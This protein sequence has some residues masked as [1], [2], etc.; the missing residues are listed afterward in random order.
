MSKIIEINP[1][2]ELIYKEFDE[3]SNDDIDLIVENAKK[4]KNWSKK[5]I[6]ERVFI[7]SKI[8]PILEEK[9]EKLAHTMASEMGKSL[10]SG[11]HEVSIIIKRIED[12]CEMIPSFIENEIIF[13]SET[14]KNIVHF[15]P[16]GVVAV[17]SPWNAPV[18]VPLA[19]IIPALLTGNNVV[20]KPS[21]YST[22]I[23]IVISEVFNELKKYG[24]PE[25]SFQLVIGGKDK[26]K[27]LVENDID[28]TVL[29]GSLRAGQQIAKSSSEKLKN[30]IL[31]LG[32]K[33]PAIVLEDADLDNSVIQIVKAATMYTGQVCFGVE[34]VYCHGKIYDEFIEKCVEEMKKI[35]VGDPMNEETDMGPFAVKF[36][37]E[38]V[39]EHIKDAINKG[40]KLIYGGK[41]IGE[42]GYFFEPTILTDVNHSMKIMKEETFGPVIPIMKFKD[43][44]EAIKLANDSD[45]GLTASIWT[46]NIKKG[47]EIARKIEAG[48]VEVNRH[49]L[50]KAGCPW[51]GYKLSGFGRI[52]SKEGIRQF[53]NTKHIWIVK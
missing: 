28:M 50:S 43:E 17:I 26:G 41:K 37:L 19:S 7:I 39:I 33:D 31:E 24:F 40:A 13:D 45:Y 49:G 14:E 44:N 35:K 5:S 46:K 42:K 25:N 51:G 23:G 48:T 20:F 4:N 11:R 34:R 15:E 18:F 12:Y 47:E 32:G 21:E 29:I 6:E 3:T 30:F 8:I 16:R 10:K 38:K 1:S 27:Y 9:R 2:T 53:M 52:Y 22:E 36:Q